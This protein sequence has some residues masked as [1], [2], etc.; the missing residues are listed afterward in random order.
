MSNPPP[1]THLELCSNDPLKHNFVLNDSCVEFSQV[2]YFFISAA[3]WPFACKNHST[4]W[5]FFLCSLFTKAV[6][7]P[8][9]YL[10]SKIKTRTFR[11]FK[12]PT[13]PRQGSN[14]PPPGA[15]KTVKC[16]WVAQGEDEA[17]NW[18]AHIEYSTDKASWWKIGDALW[19]LIPVTEQ[20]FFSFKQN[21]N[22]FVRSH[23]LQPHCINFSWNFDGNTCKKIRHIVDIHH[24][25]TLYP[26]FHRQRHTQIS[27]QRSR[28]TRING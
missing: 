11:W 27:L 5:N 21:E 4:M 17:S 14:S 8:E 22:H 7:S 9:N 25:I 16:L 24:V 26:S 13:S 10:T 23:L 20:L 28:L 6:Y 3:A 18:S 19:D 2:T 1:P 12:F 15:Q